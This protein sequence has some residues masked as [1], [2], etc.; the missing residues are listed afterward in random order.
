MIFARFVYTYAA[1]SFP[2]RAKILQCIRDESPCI[3]RFI[4]LFYLFL[5]EVC[6]HGN[7]R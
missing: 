2:A 5:F 3:L 6:R 1:R 4:G 7:S